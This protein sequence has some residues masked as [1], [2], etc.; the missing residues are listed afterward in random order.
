[1]TRKANQV[2]APVPPHEEHGGYEVYYEPEV[3]GWRYR[4]AESAPSRLSYRSAFLAR[5]A[6]DQLGTEP[7]AK[8][9]GSAKRRAKAAG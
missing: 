2:A 6:I 3:S 8:P 9:T 7:E 1:M 4:T 5:K